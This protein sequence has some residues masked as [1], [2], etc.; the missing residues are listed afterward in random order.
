M[1]PF[2]FLTRNQE[3]LAQSYLPS[4]LFSDKENWIRNRAKVRE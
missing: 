2:L 4:A 3:P 1:K